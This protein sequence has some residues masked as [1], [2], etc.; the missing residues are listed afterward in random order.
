[1]LKYYNQWV[2][3]GKIQ[4]DPAQVDIIVHLQN[5]QDSLA[6]YTG[7]P[8]KGLL[9]RLFKNKTTAP[10]GCYIYGD[11]GR[12]KSMLMDLFFDTTPI[13]RKQRIHFHAF[14]L[15]V[16]QRIFEYRKKKGQNGDPIATVAK[17]IASNIY[18]LCFDEFQVTD[19]T[20][21]MILGRLFT[22]LFKLG[23]VV[24]ATS[25]RAPDDLYKDGLQR[26]RFLPFIELLKTKV[27]V[28]ELEA[29][30]DY[31]LR[32]L[33]HLKSVY[34]SPLGKKAD[35]FMKESFA[36]LT[37]KAEPVPHALNLPGRKLHLRKT[38]G[39]VL[40]ATFS[41]LCQQPLGA[42]DYLEIATE[43][44]TVLLADIPKMQKSDRNEAKR[45]VTLIDALYEYRVKLIC[46][47]QTKPISLY[48]EGDGS[49]EFGRTVSRLTE[50]QS[51]AYLA[52]AHQPSK[53]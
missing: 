6:A 9:S 43:F 30:Q 40:W 53:G 11:V 35:L 50:M 32:H 13:T 52:E 20:D 44:S 33:H 39:D 8:Q 10:R 28:L 19:I 23:V 7:H 16:H 37:N 2:S 38:H 49:F 1:M 27:R 18:L 5:L 26:Q 36:E 12:G 29:E 14:M 15:D 24:V 41:E 31:R 3:E 17:D 45:F 22:E 4:P 34:F 25:N 47:A 42:A 21:A 46:T 48:P 51:E